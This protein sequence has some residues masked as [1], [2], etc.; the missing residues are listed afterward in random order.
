M[1]KFNENYSI[2]KKRT[3]ISTLKIPS[4]IFLNISKNQNE[5]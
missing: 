5:N 3:Q 2:M 1:N 4:K